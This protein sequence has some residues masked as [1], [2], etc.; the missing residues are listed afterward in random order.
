VSIWKEA[1]SLA[2]SVLECASDFGFNPTTD[3]GRPCLS[4]VLVGTSVESHWPDPKPLSGEHRNLLQPRLGSVLGLLHGTACPNLDVQVCWPLVQN[5]AQRAS[6]LGEVTFRW[7][8]ARSNSSKEN[9]SRWKE[10]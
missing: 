9:K 7:R 1:A 5:L 3:A 6:M 2:S 10:V 4:L 8:G